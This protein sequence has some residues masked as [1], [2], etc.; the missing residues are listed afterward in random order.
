MGKE[1]FNWQ[2]EILSGMSTQAI[3][4]KLRELIPGFNL[5]SFLNKA[6]KY[7]SCE[8]L[9]EDEYYPRATFSDTDEDFIWMAC[10]ELW[11]RFIPDRPSVEYVAEQLDGLVEKTDKAADRERWKEVLLRSQEALDLI[12]RHTIEEISGGR[13]LRRDFYDKLCE[14]TIYDFDSLLDVLVRNLMEHEKY[15]RVIGI[16]EILA[17]AAA[18]DSLLDCKA[19][20]LFALGRKA[21]SERLYRRIIDRNPDDP[22]YLLHAGDCHVIYGEKDFARARDCYLKAL[23]IVQKHIEEPE[24]KDDLHEV[25]K[26]LISVASASGRSAEAMR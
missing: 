20:S 16:V 2:P 18:D 15:E 3:V 8:D 11:K 25:Y 4:D 21:D 12:C 10:E 1:S 19:E 6:Q 22:R 5:D 13:R 24:A 7:L 14:A 9:S 26:R 23:K 17:D